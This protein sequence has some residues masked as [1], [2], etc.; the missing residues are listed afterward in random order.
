MLLIKLLELDSCT[1]IRIRMVVHNDT[2]LIV[3]I[4]GV[5]G[6]SIGIGI[7]HIDTRIV[8]IA[9]IIHQI[10]GMRIVQTNS[11]TIGITGVVAQG[12]RN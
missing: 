7:I 11:E 6:Q 12:I 4:A 10:I 5:I 8:R 2:I 1:L 3:S 9:G